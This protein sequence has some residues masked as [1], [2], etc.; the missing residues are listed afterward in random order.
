MGQLSIM[1]LYL[2]GV[3]RKEL[4]TKVGRRSYPENSLHYNFFSVIKINFQTEI[5]SQCPPYHR[6]WRSWNLKLNTFLTVEGGDCEISIAYGE[7][8]L[9]L[10]GNN[11]RNSAWGNTMV[12]HQRCYLILISTKKCY[13]LLPSSHL[14]LAHSKDFY[15]H[16]VWRTTLG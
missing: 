11:V 4:L 12:F 16:P 15:P 7:Q 5:Q 3:Q 2:L 8:T 14:H 10:T 6:G 9:P 13:W 1:F